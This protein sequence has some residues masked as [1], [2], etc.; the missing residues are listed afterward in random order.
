[1]ILTIGIIAAVLI[2]LY[3]GFGYWLFNLPNRKPR[4]V[5]RYF[6]PPRNDLPIP[7]PEGLRFY[8]VDLD[9]PLIC[10]YGHRKAMD[11]LEDRWMPGMTMVEVSAMLTLARKKAA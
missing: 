2:L 3:I 11:E 5:V 10:V 8:V 6:I 7:L 4:A 1:M 9:V